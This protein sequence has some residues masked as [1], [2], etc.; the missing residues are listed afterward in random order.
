MGTV[1]SIEEL[2]KIIGEP[3]ETVLRKVKG[4]IDMHS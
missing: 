2:K 4:E 3:K 1:T